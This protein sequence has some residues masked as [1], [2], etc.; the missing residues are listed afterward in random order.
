M[1]VGCGGN[2][3]PAAAPPTDD[4]PVGYTP[5]TNYPLLTAPIVPGVIPDSVREGGTPA[6][7]PAVVEIGNF[8]QG[9]NAE[10]Y[11]TVYNGTDATT[12]FAITYR[13][14][15]NAR[16]GYV[17]ATNLQQSWVTIASP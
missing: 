12:T 8:H 10:W 5:P 15:D 13:L 7:S 3:A 1:A 6:I 17:K 2:E 14:P 4:Q 16:E 9:S 11:M